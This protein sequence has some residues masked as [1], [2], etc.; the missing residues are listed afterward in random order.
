MQYTH[1]DY[2]TKWLLSGEQHTSVVVLL[3]AAVHKVG[4]HATAAAVQRDHKLLAAGAK[5]YK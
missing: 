3:V 2:C 1:M 4:V 5:D